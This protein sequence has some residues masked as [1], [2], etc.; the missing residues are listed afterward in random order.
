MS[1]NAC[2]Q[3]HMD[4]VSVCWDKAIIAFSISNISKIKVKSIL[5]E[6][7]IL[8]EASE[9]NHVGR[10]SLNNLRS[11]TSYTIEVIFGQNSQ[12]LNFTTLPEPVGPVL[13]TYAAIAD[14]HISTKDE[15]RKGRLFVESASILYDVVSE[16]NANAVEFVLIA[17]D[18]TN[19]GTQQE[20]SIAKKALDTLNCSIFAVPGDHDTSIDTSNNWTENFGEKQWCRDFNGFRLIGLDTSSDYLG[21]VGLSFLTENLPAHNRLPIILSHLQLFPDNYITSNFRSKICL[22]Y[23]KYSSEIK[24]LSGIPTIV[25]SGH[26]NIPS[27]VSLHKS[28]Q[29]NV[30]QTV[31]FPCGYLLVRRYANGLYHTFM[32]IRSEVLNEHSRIA[33]NKAAD[34]Y[35]EPQ[36]RDTYRQGSSL[37]QSNFLFPYSEIPLNISETAKIRRKN[38]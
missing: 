7:A 33:G 31:Q 30:P 18:V 37:T 4:V 38:L 5:P 21:Q 35:G 25:Y 3:N 6:E 36:W 15:N 11:N 10:I 24:G 28:I 32:P 17:G 13:S 1:D 14:T 8:A 16:I 2:K 20:Y 19:S 26:Q 34:Q 22:D 9:H 23:D 27:R 12:R 29:I